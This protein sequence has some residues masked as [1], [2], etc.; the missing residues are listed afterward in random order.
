MIQYGS[1]ETELVG[2]GRSSLAIGVI[3][4]L[5]A[6]EELI[7]SIIGKAEDLLL[8]SLPLAPMFANYWHFC[9][10]KWRGDKECS[11]TRRT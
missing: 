4:N 11:S 6:C 10:E 1:S 5:L 3:N 2:G 7:D 8:R 9:G